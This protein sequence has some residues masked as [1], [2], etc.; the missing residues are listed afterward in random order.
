MFEAGV[1]FL[2]VS[3]VAT[4]AWA[5][6]RRTGR[7]PSLA[8]RVEPFPAGLKHLAS[9]V[10]DLSDIGIHLPASTRAMARKRRLGAL[11]GLR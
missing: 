5:L 6:R 1:A 2:T 11:L 4:L 9:T 10:S 7:R 3:I 8:A